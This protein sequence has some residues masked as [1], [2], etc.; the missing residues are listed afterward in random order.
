M[1]SQS[2]IVLSSDGAWS[3]FENDSDTSLSVHK[4]DNVKSTHLD[5][6]NVGD[7]L[8][9]LPKIIPTKLNSDPIKYNKSTSWSC[10][11]SKK[12]PKDRSCDLK[13]ESTAASVFQSLT[14]KKSESK[15]LKDDLEDKLTVNKKHYHKKTDSLVA[16]R[17]LPGPKCNIRQR[18]LSKIIPTKVYDCVSKSKLQSLTACK[19][20]KPHALLGDVKDKLAANTKYYHKKTDSLVAGRDLPGPKCNIRQ[21]ILPKIIPTKVYDCVSKSKL[22]SLTACKNS[23]PHA[24]LGDVKDKLAANTKHY[25]KTTDCLVAGRKLPG[26]K[27]HV[28]PRVSP[29][30]TPVEFYDGSISTSVSSKISDPKIRS[31]NTIN[32]YKCHTCCVCSDAKKHHY[33]YSVGDVKNQ[34]VAYKTSVE[35]N[36]DRYTYN[37]SSSKLAKLTNERF[38]F[39]NKKSKKK[40]IINI[41]TN[42]TNKVKKP[43]P[44]ARKSSSFINRQAREKEVDRTNFILMKKLLHVKPSISTFH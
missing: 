2:N 36:Y 34:C 13:K 11:A 26:E 32:T 33:A 37:G 29:K 40:Q 14:G 17:D 28:R 27:I 15:V 6:G 5:Q 43:A 23:K 19:N 16:G 39:L 30:T 41:Y 12:V 10:K 18:I 42:N 7:K 44:L 24:L 8:R 9:I 3:I 21:R 20:S 25:H 4:A 1:K 22:Q 38:S 35:K 31:I